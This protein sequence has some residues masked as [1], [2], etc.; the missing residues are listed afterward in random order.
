MVAV[1]R[2]ISASRFLL[3]TC[4]QQEAQLRAIESS[5]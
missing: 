1:I 4:L 2:K 3:K 5:E